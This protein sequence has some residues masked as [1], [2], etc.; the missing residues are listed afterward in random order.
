MRIPDGVRIAPG[1]RRRALAEK[2]VLHLQDCR[3]R[4]QDVKVKRT[5]S[6]SAAIAIVSGIMAAA[7]L[8]NVLLAAYLAAAV[9]LGLVVAILAYKSVRHV[10]HWYLSA[11]VPR[12]FTRFLR[13]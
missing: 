10:W 2:L 8:S 7:V 9:S 3:R 5:F 11:R 6:R 12:V 13:E 1:V 4:L